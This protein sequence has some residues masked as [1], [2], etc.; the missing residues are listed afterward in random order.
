MDLVEDVYDTCNSRKNAFGKTAA[1]H[2]VLEQYDLK[3]V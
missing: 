3:D 1:L 2:E